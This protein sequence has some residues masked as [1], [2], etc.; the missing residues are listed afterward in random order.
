MDAGSCMCPFLTQIRGHLQPE[1]TDLSVFG[2]GKL[3]ADNI[4]WEPNRKFFFKEKDGMKNPPLSSVFAFNLL[5]T[6]NA[7]FTLGS[8]MLSGTCFQ[9]KV[10]V[11]VRICTFRVAAFKEFTFR[12]TTQVY[13]SVFRL[14]IQNVEPSNTHWKLDQLSFGQSQIRIW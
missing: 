11:N 9:F 7:T 12:V 13:K 2:L 10:Y 6:S 3:P 5:L 1:K 14:Y 4:W 8:E